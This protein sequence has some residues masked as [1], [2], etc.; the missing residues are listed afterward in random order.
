[1][2][3]VDGFQD[4]KTHELKPV[5]LPLRTESIERCP[6]F[7]TLWNVYVNAGVK[8]PMEV[9]NVACIHRYIV[10]EKLRD[11]V[12]FATQCSTVVLTTSTEPLKRSSMDYVP[13]DDDIKRVA[14]GG[15]TYRLN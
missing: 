8:I 11:L 12:Q 1:M 10:M 15:W 6:G 7:E 14:C 5:A 9:G 3:A 13:K 4:S 2:F